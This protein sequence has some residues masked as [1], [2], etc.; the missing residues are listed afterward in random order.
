MTVQSSC[1]SGSEGDMGGSG[2]G[3]PAGKGGGG[4]VDSI[5]PLILPF[6]HDYLVD[7]VS[8][9]ATVPVVPE[10]VATFRPA[11]VPSAAPSFVD[12]GLLA[13]R[14]TR[15]WRSMKTATQ[16]LVASAP[17]AI[18]LST[19][20]KDGLAR[21]REESRVCALRSRHCASDGRRARLTQ[22]ARF[23]Q[24]HKRAGVLAA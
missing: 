20:G 24:A 9:F 19:G 16:L 13:K 7:A 18:L 4:G 17:N 3:K 14:Q 23:V 15:T 10:A 5:L 6:R 21:V 1:R 2:G 12:G 8:L 11:I 22:R